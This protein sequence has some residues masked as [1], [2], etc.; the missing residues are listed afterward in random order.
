MKKVIALDDHP[1]VLAGLQN[2]LETAPDVEFCGGFQSVTDALHWLDSNPTDV[3]L[4]DIHLGADDGIQVCKTLNS[5]FPQLRIIALSNLEQTAIVRQML[6]NGAQGYL[7]KNAQPN[8]LLAAIHGP[9]TYLQ[10]ALQEFLAR[11]A[12]GITP[13][14][15]DFIPVLTRREREVLQCIAQG[16][17]TKEIARELFISVDTVETH[18]GHLFQKMGVKNAT[19]LLKIALEKGL[20]T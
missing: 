13:A 2:L 6:K 12:L 20:I 1:V 10:P 4:L 5:R 3:L 9:G 16:L 15:R 7:L 18:R 19:S 17:T 8:E 14:A 11:E